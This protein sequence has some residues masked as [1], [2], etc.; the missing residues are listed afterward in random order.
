VKVSTS[1]SAPVLVDLLQRFAS[2]HDRY[3][4]NSH[5]DGDAI[6]PVDRGDEEVIIPYSFSFYL[7]Y[8]VC[9]VIVMLLV[10]YH[11]CTQDGERQQLEDANN[12]ELMQLTCMYQRHQRVLDQLMMQ[13][14]R[15]GKTLKNF[16]PCE[17][18]WY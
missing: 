18:D 4:H 14:V 10:L 6:S 13:R 3:G 17:D 12:S 5:D 11:V 9:I 1:A 2:G 16:S 7:S 8:S 15:L